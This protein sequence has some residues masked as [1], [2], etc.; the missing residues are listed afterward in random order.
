MTKYK[1]IWVNG[2]EKVEGKSVEDA[3][4]KIKTDPMSIVTGMLVQVNTELKD[5]QQKEGWWDSEMFWKYL[6]RVK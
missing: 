2:E 4:G 5:K 1:F 6:K 3:C